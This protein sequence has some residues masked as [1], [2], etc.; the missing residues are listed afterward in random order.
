MKRRRTPVQTLRSTLITF[1]V[2][3][4][5][6]AACRDL[7]AA[8]DTVAVLLAGGGAAARFDVGLA[9]GFVMLR[10][11]VWLILPGLLARDAVIAL[12]D[13]NAPVARDGG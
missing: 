10:L 6:E 11:L 2:A 9:I 7:F 8:R 13:R 5:L 1:V 12:F 3:V 4:V